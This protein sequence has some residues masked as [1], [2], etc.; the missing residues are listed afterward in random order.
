MKVFLCAIVSWAGILA[1]VNYAK[2]APVPPLQVEN[3]VRDADL[4]VIGRVLRDR[5]KRQDGTSQRIESFVEGVEIEVSSTLK[6]QSDN[7]VQVQFVSTSIFV[8]YPSI[9]RNRFRIY[10]LKRDRDHFTFV[11]PY[12]PSLTAVVGA[13]ISAADPLERVI[14]ALAGAASSSELELSQRLEAANTLRNIDGQATT[15]ILTSLLRDRERDIRLTATVGLIA[16]DDMTALVSGERALLKPNADLGSDSEL[17]QNLRA[18][19]AGGIRNPAAIPS[20][21][22][23]MGSADATV[24]RAA[25]SALRHVGT[26]AAVPLL[27]LCLDDTDTEV[28]HAAVSGL[29]EIT[30]NTNVRVTR[31]MFNSHREEYLAFWKD[32]AKSHRR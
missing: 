28:Q 22:R 9:D 18:S 30:G 12:H 19:I 14:E 7:V 23:L 3:L 20:L 32:W 17:L 1:L 5:F 29:A 27:V 6:G 25:A 26:N 16:R 13:H 15:L 31:E 4:I 24:R 2:A 8:G 21:G 10:F 11:N